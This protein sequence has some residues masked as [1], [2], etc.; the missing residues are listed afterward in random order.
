MKKILDRLGAYIIK[1]LLRSFS[2]L[3]FKTISR[4]GFLGLL[5]YYIFPLR[6]KML[7]ENLIRTGICKTEEECVPVIKG[8]Y[9]CQMLNFFEFFWMSNMTKTSVINKNFRIHGLSNFKKAISG[10]EGGVIISSHLDNWELLAVAIGKIGVKMSALIVDRDIEV[11]KVISA[12]RVVTG[13]GVMD[14]N[15]SAL[16]CM[17]LIKRKNFAGIV[18]DQHTDNAGVKTKFMGLDC[19]STS[20]PAALSLKTGCPIYGVF[21]IR[22][23][24]YKSH[25]IYIEPALYARD[26]TLAEN[27]EKEAIVSCTQAINDMIERYIKMAPEQWFWFHKRWRA[28]VMPAAEKKEQ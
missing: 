7:V 25:D 6:K 15:H 21:M 13:N 20:L 12:A 18:S 11:H 3:E 27:D 28:S 19:M 22:S 1:K 16:K 14:R 23:A 26:F 8:I 10:E 9:T 4:F 5:F 24:D 2:L 17:R